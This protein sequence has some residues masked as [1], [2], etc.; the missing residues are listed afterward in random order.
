MKH[1]VCH[2]GFIPVRTEPQETSE[3]CTQILFGESYEVLAQQGKW[4][5]IRMDYD[6]FDKWFMRKFDEEAYITINSNNGKLLSFLYLKVEDADENYSDMTPPLPPKRRLKVGTFKVISN[7][8]TNDHNT[9][10][11]DF[12]LFFI[13]NHIQLYS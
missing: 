1:S 6:G 13:V 12:L 11:N 3:M 10:K 8:F 7:G 5:R 4:L 2:Y 9:P